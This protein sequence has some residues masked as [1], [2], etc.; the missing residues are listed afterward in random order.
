MT[1]RLISCCAALML[2]AGCASSPSP[3][4]TTT[5]STSTPPVSSTPATTTTTLPVTPTPTPVVAPGTFGLVEPQRA[6]LFVSPTVSFQWTGSE[7]ATSYR[8]EVATSPAFGTATVI[9]RANLTTTSFQPTTP[10]ARATAYWWRVTATNSAGSAV[11]D[12]APNWFSVPLRVGSSADGLAISPDG[13]FAW[14]TNNTNHG[15]V[16]KVDLANRS[17]QLTI[18]L[19]GLPGHIAV[20]PDGKTVVVG[21]QNNLTVI[22]AATGAIRRV[23]TAPC[24]GTTLY[25]FVIAPDSATLY[26]PDLTPSCI[27]NDIDVVNLASG[28][29]TTVLTGTFAGENIALSHD[30]SLALLT[31]GVASSSLATWA[32][33]TQIVAPFKFNASVSVVIAPDGMS[34]FVCS[35]GDSTQRLSTTNHTV[36]RYFPYDGTQGLQDLAVSP[37]GSKL[38]I[39]GRFNTEVV[40]VVNGTL[41][42]RTNTGGEMVAVMPDGRTALQT[43]PGW[44]T[45]IPLE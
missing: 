16:E 12:N 26:M 39:N 17:I 23:I 43:T 13:K 41:V 19:G 30:G 3:T 22:D 31:A 5:P 42:H 7:G 10:L 44:L 4:T 24:V 1:L 32:T 14:V 34:A 9:D 11:I 37:D 40:T 35:E 15:D 2:L 29:I 8:L 36:L 21:R 6:N 45:A 38:V 27:G 28:A 20:S 18:P 33:D 25:G